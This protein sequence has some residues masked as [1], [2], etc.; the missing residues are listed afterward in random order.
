M[1]EMDKKQVEFGLF[2]LALG[3]LWA[4]VVSHL[5]LEAGTALELVEDPLAVRQPSSDWMIT[6]SDT[7]ARP[8][9]LPR[10]PS[11]TVLRRG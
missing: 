7:P 5:A 9:T 6:W 1:R 8:P 11:K 3:K 4:A 10:P 2:K